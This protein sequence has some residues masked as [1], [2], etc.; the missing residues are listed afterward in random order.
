MAHDLNRALE[1]LAYLNK[2]LAGLFSLGDDLKALQALFNQVDELGREKTKL[3]AEVISIKDTA[4][5]EQANAKKKVE[6]VEQQVKNAEQSVK[7]AIQAFEATQ[8]KRVSLDREMSKLL[9]DANAKAAACIT[10]A[11]KEA[12]RIVA[13]ARLEAQKAQRERDAIKTELSKLRSKF[14]N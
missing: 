10:D 9:D 8:A 5:T 7:E 12:D 2:R 6:A 13:E 11:R 4:A 14:S 3:L 1:D